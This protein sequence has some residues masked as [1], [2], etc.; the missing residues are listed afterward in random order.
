MRERDFLVAAGHECEQFSTA[1]FRFLEREAIR[2]A[3]AELC[4][5]H[6]LPGLHGNIM[7]VALWD[8]AALDSFGAFWA[9]FRRLD[10]ERRAVVERCA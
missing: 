5:V 1:F 9:R 7:R 2:L 6:V 4:S 10:H 8:D 3:E